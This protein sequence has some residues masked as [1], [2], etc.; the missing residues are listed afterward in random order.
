MPTHV[1][2]FGRVGIVIAVVVFL[3][4]GTVVAK[5]NTQRDHDRD[6]SVL[7]M[8]VKTPVIAFKNVAKVQDRLERHVSSTLL[9]AGVDAF[10]KAVRWFSQEEKAKARSGSSS[11][12]RSL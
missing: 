1:V 5:P 9:H 11:L 4:A 6:R 12:P 3:A 10:T 7:V 8:L 2:R